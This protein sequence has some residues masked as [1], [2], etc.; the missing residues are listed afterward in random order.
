MIT[1]RLPLVVDSNLKSAYALYKLH[2]N[3]KH[4]TILSTLSN[5]AGVG[6][7]FACRSLPAVGR[8]GISGSSANFWLLISLVSP[9]DRTG[10]LIDH[11]ACVPPFVGVQRCCK[12]VVFPFAALGPGQPLSWPVFFIQEGRFFLLTDVTLCTVDQWFRFWCPF[13][14]L[15]YCVKPLQNFGWIPQLCSGSV[16]RESLHSKHLCLHLQFLS[17][18]FSVSFHSLYLLIFHFPILSS[19]FFLFFLSYPFP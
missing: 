14:Q 10:S 5:K 2:W 13:K 7:A 18:D 16:T 15:N 4:Q 6:R 11:T 9:H 3:C 8:N 17:T 1:F 19:P 12:F